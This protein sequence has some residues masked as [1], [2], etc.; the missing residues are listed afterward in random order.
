MAR[1]AKGL[2]KHPQ[3]GFRLTIGKK[4][5][6]KPRLFWLGHARTT[7]E[8]HADA[9]KGQFDFMK[10]EG[11]DIWTE[12]DKA[13]V[14]WHLAQFKQAMGLL[15]DR[16]RGD[17]RQ[18]D[19]Q[20]NTLEQKSQQQEALL[21]EAP[22]PAPE[23]PTTAAPAPGRT[24]HDAIKAYLD[25][26][27]GKRVSESHKWRARQV[28]DT[29]LKSVRKDCPLADV[30]FLWLDRLADYFKARPMGTKFKRPMRPETVATTLRYFRSFFVWLDDTEFGGWEEPRKLLRPFRV[31]AADLMT[32]DELRE[33]T[34]IEQFDVGTLVK[35]YKAGNAF[36]QMVMMSALFTGGTQE[37]T[38]RFD[39]G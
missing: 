8:Y 20:R 31:R 38:F 2:S 24:L 29:V 34:T 10:A 12:A 18:L 17:E 11:R 36:Q 4:T 9:L 15:R 16:H 30:D 21:G 19:E 14:K 22:A 5:D 23:Q 3:H 27:D 7:A 1:T 32:T 39:E 13:R 26:L 37:R 25:T 28:V 6:G 35:L 33:S